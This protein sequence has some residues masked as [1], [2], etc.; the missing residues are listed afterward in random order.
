M[1][2]EHRLVVGTTDAAFHEG[3]AVKMEINVK[4]LVKKLRVRAARPDFPFVV[5]GMGNA[6]CVA[7]LEEGAPQ[8]ARQ[9]AD[10]V[11][12]QRSVHLHAGKVGIQ[13]CVGAAGGRLQL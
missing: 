6:R 11:R 1:E 4:N 7:R 10:G 9:L 13:H 2:G 5:R 3:I 8:V 12:S